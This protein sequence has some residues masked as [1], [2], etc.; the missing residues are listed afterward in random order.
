MSAGRTLA[1]IASGIIALV[2]LAVVV[3][4]LAGT[5][6]PQQFAAGSPEAAVQGYLAAWDEGDAEA[7]WAFFSSEV[8]DSYSFEDYERAIDEYGLYSYP[9]GGPRRSV[10]IDGVE[11]GGERLTVQLTV[12]EYYGDGLN[13][14]SYRSPRSVRLIREEGAWKIRDPLIW[15]DPAPFGEPLLEPPF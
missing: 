15:L 4:L 14:S 12:D 3:V 6:S 9:E 7:T 5:R 13:T 2:L 10:Y 11:G 1:L 8:Q